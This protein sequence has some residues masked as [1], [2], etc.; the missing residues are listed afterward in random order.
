MVT[1]RALRYFLALVQE[2]HFGRAAARVNIS[3]PALS[4]QIRDLEVALKVTLVERL[5]RDLQVTP[6]GREVA[7]QAE[8]ILAEVGALEQMARGHG[9][10]TRL[11]LGVIPTVAPYLLPSVLP[12]L[13]AVDIRRD[14]RLR[15]ATTDILLA[16]LQ[17]GTLDAV[18]V[19]WQASFDGMEVEPLFEDRFLLAGRR[20]QLTALMARDT[21][22][23]PVSLDPD[24]L[25]LLDE[26][27]CL[28]DQ[29]LEVCGLER[30]GQ[31]LDLGASS[32]STLSGLVGN[33]LGL[34]FLP[35]IALATE[36]AAVPAMA[37]RRF[38]TPEPSR[39][40]V[41]VRRKGFRPKSTGP[42]RPAWFEELAAE[43][44]AAGQALIAR[45][46]S[47]IPLAE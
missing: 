17:K 7:A 21:A 9:L 35:E 19:A 42:A 20:G 43:C 29:A 4:M 45:A 37:A 47:I 40:I 26:G 24:Q 34:T 2:R 1:L 38:A 11:N 46:R 33:G 31:R 5:G 6:A 23:H 18:V 15:E 27:H 44:A 28:A 8:R 36:L 12:A 30:R 16:A 32:L 39:Q 22:M 25:L 13:R 10:E 14:L 3:Q 41:L